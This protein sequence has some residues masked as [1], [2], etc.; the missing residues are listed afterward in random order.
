MFE[1]LKHFLRH[2]ICCHIGGLFPTYIEVLQTSFQRMSFFIA[3]KNT[4]LINLIFQR[5]G[6][7]RENVSIC[8]FNFTLYQ[9]LEHIDVCRYFVRRRNLQ[10]YFSFLGIDSVVEGDTKSNADFI[11]FV[12][13]NIEAQFAFRRHTSTP[14]LFHPPPTMYQTL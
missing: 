6:T 1:L 14:R 3:L 9:N 2:D 10:D 7:L 12:W 4:P 11:H 8:R 5:G 13:R